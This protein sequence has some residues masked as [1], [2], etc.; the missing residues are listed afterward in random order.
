MDLLSKVR[1]TV[2][3][4]SK[5]SDG[6]YIVTVSYEKMNILNPRWSCTRTMWQR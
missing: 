1:Y 6:S 2:D 5:Q 4:A 3:E